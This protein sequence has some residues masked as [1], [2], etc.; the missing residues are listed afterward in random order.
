MTDIL[1]SELWKGAYN[2]STQYDVSDCVSYLGSSYTCILR[3]AIGTV[4]TN[5]TYWKLFAQKGTDGAGADAVVGP[6]SATDNAIPLFDGTT[7]K[8]IKDGSN[9]LIATV[10]PD[11]VNQLEVANA[12]TNNNPTTT[13]SGGDDNVGW[14]IKMKGTGRFRKPTVIEIP[15]FGPATDTA[16]GD[17]KA[18]FR[19]PEE[20]NGMNLTGV[21]ACVYTAGT[22]NTTI[23]Q[24]RNHTDT[25]DMLSTRLSID[26]EEVDSSTAATP[27]VIDTTKDD[28][29]TGDIIA[30]DCDQVS[31][32]PAKG[33]L[34]QLRFELP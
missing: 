10:V 31:T 25:A 22:T 2:A 34:I 16:T 5:T 3:P 11:A 9:L 30:I 20:L 7:G 26:S 27:A 32:T 15:V 6:A 1:W 8:L 21:A 13:A 17:G 24:V 23:F 18:M 4:P 12:A 14:D 28:I 29:V 33:A 19:V